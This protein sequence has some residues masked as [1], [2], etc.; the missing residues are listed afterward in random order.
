MTTRR[1]K[2]AALVAGCAVVA[3]GGYAAADAL[4]GPASSSTAQASSA[5]SSSAL[6]NSEGA[7]LSSAV[8]GAGT[9]AN[10]S[11]TGLKAL[12]KRRILAALRRLPGEYGQFSYETRKKGE[13]VLA[14]ERGTITSV[15]G[16]TVTVRAANG[17]TE[18]WTLTGRSRV[19]EAGKRTSASALA[20]GE[21]V[22]VAGPVSGSARDARVIVVRDMAARKTARKST[23]TTTTS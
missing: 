21:K 1:T 13:K 7:A 6:S 9:A 14:F 8:D 3:G 22:F 15:S 16:Q 12:K 19:R 23:T 20:D 17:H 2:T 11:A 10:T 5:P 18:D 4:A